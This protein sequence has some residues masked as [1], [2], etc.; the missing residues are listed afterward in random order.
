ML[1]GLTPA[2]LASSGM[3]MRPAG[4]RGDSD[5]TGAQLIAW[6]FRPRSG[7]L[8]VGRLRG[9]TIGA[10]ASQAPERVR[11]AARIS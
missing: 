10:V 2:R 11:L 7:A 4:L 8:D 5:G 9:R 1:V 3:V 6:R